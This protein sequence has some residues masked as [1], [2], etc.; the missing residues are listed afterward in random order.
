MVGVVVTGKMLLPFK[1]QKEKQNKNF[2]GSIS[3][4]FYGLLEWAGRGLS[5]SV[6]VDVVTFGS[7]KDH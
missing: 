5:K 6:T 1:A 3:G 7:P 2:S 4:N